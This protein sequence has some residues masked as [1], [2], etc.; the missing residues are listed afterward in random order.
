MQCFVFL[1]TAF[2]CQLCQTA[3]FSTHYINSRALKI[4]STSYIQSNHVAQKIGSHHFGLLSQSGKNEPMSLSYH[5]RV[6][7]MSLADASTSMVEGSSTAEQILKS[8]HSNSFLFRCVVSITFI[9]LD[10]KPLK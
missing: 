4:S 1:V 7:F 8:I 9:P 6:R 5:P 2:I 10:L 3:A